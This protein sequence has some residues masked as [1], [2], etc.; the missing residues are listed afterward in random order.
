MSPGTSRDSSRRPHRPT[1]GAW[2]ACSGR[3]K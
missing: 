2:F 1:V 3:G